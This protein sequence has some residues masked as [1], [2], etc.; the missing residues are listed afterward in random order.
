MK[1]NLYKPTV[2]YISTF[3]TATN[4]KYYYAGK[5]VKANLSSTYFGSGKNVKTLV[6]KNAERTIVQE[7][8][9][10]IDA[11]ICEIETIAKLKDKF[12]DKCLN[13]AKGGI[14]GQT[15]ENKVGIP[16]S[17]EHKQ[18]ISRSLKGKTRI[19]KDPNFNKLHKLWID[20]DKPSRHKFRKLA[21]A[22]GFK[23]KNYHQMLNHFNT[24]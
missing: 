18:A 22:N 3:T 17:E 12:G 9:N 13:I 23:D 10:Q 6:Y 1:H 4:E 5:R 11:S 2:V 16:L 14:G 8:D 21:V 20:N 7:F 19:N 24:I 15:N